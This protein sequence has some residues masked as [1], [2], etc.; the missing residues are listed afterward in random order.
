MYACMKMKIMATMKWNGAERSTKRM[1]D[2]LDS[3]KKAAEKRASRRRVC[4]WWCAIDSV[5]GGFQ[6][7]GKRE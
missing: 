5:R 2:E 1:R 3:K 7:W 4:A 6:R